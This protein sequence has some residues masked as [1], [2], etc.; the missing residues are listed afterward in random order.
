M[1]DEKV[2]ASDTKT[3]AEN[4]LRLVTEEVAKALEARVAELEAVV[5]V[6]AEHSRA[7]EHGIVVAWLVNVDARIKD[8]VAKTL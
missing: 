6:L 2:K 8:A 4:P 5:K 3:P 7:A 1:T